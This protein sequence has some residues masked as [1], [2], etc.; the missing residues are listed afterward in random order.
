MLDESRLVKPTHKTLTQVCC[1]RSAYPLGLPEEYAFL[2]V[3]RMNGRTVTKNWNLWQIQDLDTIEQLSVGMNGEKQS[4]EFSY[5]TPDK[6][7][8]TAAFSFLPFLFDSQW[9]KIVLIVKRGTVSLFVDC[10]MIDSQSLSP[11]GEVNLDGFTVIGKLKDNPA[12]AVPVSL[13]WVTLG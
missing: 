7:R 13:I 6:S 8:Q 12:I 3:F 10:V 1:L 11:R 9:H 4:L 5:T 2:T